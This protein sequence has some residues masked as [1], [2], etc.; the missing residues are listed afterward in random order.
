MLPIGVVIEGFA[1][2]LYTKLNREYIP[3]AEQKEVNLA[4]HVL[5]PCLYALLALSTAVAVG[6][7]LVLP[8]ASLVRFSLFD[9]VL[10]HVKGDSLYSVGTSA[11]TDKLL[12]SIAARVGVE[13]ETLVKILKLIALVGAGGLVLLISV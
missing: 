2:G 5:Y 4:L 11:S 12:R 1:Q 3:P 9:L 8:I 7:L 10:N 6:S 13:V